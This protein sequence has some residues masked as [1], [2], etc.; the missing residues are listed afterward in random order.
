[1][2]HRVHE[3]RSEVSFGGDPTAVSHQVLES[4]DE[5]LREVTVANA[6]SAVR[7]VVLPC[8]RSQGVLLEADESEGCALGYDMLIAR[9]FLRPGG[10]S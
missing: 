10:A 2:L 5:L 9:S 8:I 7:Q 6:I 1:M 4:L 3:D